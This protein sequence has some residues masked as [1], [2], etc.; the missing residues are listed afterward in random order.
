MTAI[1]SLR[2]SAAHHAAVLALNA[3]HERETGPLDQ[4][5]LSALLATAFAAPAA[6]DGNGALL[7]FLLCLPEAAAYASPN[8]AWVSAR[9]RAFAY[10]DRVVVAPGARGKGIGRMLYGAAEAQARAAGLAWLACEVNLDPPN[11]VS[12]AFHAALGYQPIGVARQP[13]RGKTMR[14]LA[15]PLEL[16][17]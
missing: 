3:A 11:P 17:P 16:S 10:I 12:D 8:Y 6:I 13:A 4:A 9:L 15:L 5:G 7:G 1:V 2:D 14:Y